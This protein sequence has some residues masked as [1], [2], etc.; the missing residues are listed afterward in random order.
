MDSHPIISLKGWSDQTVFFQY[1]LEFLKCALL[2]GGERKPAVTHF[3]SHKIHGFFD[4]DG[5]DVAEQGVDHIKIFHL[6]LT[7]LFAVAL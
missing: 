5:I 4:R 2:H 3:H 7:A 6:E 1:I